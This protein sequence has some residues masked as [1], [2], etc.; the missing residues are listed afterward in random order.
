MQ[1]TDYT[2]NHLKHTFLPFQTICHAYSGMNFPKS[3]HNALH[4]YDQY[5]RVSGKL[6][7]P[8]LTQISKLP[9]A[10]YLSFHDFFFSVSTFLCTETRRNV[11]LITQE[12]IILLYLPQNSDARIVHVGRESFLGCF[13]RVCHL[14]LSYNT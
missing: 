3:W 7:T 5:Y 11:S 6:F 8:R 10:S 2:Q 9:I 12:L 4:S 1:F 13:P 14:M